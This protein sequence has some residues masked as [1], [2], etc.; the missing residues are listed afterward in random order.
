MTLDL[1]PPTRTGAILPESPCWGLS[2]VLMRTTA[3]AV[4]Q[5]D[6]SPGCSP[7]GGFT[8]RDVARLPLGRSTRRRDR[9]KLPRRLDP[10]PVRAPLSCTPRPPRTTCGQSITCS[11]A[12]KP[13]HTVLSP[14]TPRVGRRETA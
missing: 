9:A 5:T 8:R 13:F 6:E 14:T 2:P 10:V 3:E 1:L 4:A 12:H 7:S 11:I